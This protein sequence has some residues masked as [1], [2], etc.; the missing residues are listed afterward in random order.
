MHSRKQHTYEYVKSYLEDFG[1]TLISKEYK[2]V[3]TKLKMQCPKKHNIEIRFN[4]FKSGGD[5]CGICKYETL[6]EKFSG[7]GCYNWNPNR[8]EVKINKRLRR[9]FKDSWVK[10]HMKTDKEYNNF[11]QDPSKYSIDHIIPVSL[12]CKVVTHFNLDEQ[13]VKKII[14]GRENLQ[15]LTKE[16]NFRK[17][18]HGSS[19]FEACQYLMLKGV[20][21]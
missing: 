19:M 11:I 10:N 21:F 1:F 17:F 5:R 2:N 3:K 13:V 15:I 8:E 12:F 18:N 16:E 9:Y 14:N 20:K 6:S 4:G 7:E